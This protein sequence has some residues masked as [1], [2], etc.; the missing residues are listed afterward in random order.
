MEQA[1]AAYVIKMG[2]RYFCGFGRK[3]QVMTAWCLTGAT[4]FMSL[5]PKH[6]ILQKL[7]EKK[8]RFKVVKIGESEAFNVEPEPVQEVI[9]YVP[10]GEPRFYCD[11]GL[12]F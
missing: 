7:Q 6:S 4:L 11:D 2:N 3:G 10:N 9:P 8:K 5:S 12:P 1:N